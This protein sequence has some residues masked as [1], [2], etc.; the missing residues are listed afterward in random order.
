MC[1]N[2]EKRSSQPI[3]LALWKWYTF[4]GGPRIVSKPGHVD[5]DTKTFSCRS[6]KTDR[7]RK[8]PTVFDFFCVF[9][10]LIRYCKMAQT[11]NLYPAPQSHGACARCGSTVPSLGT[12]HEHGKDPGGTSS[13]T[14]CFWHST[15]TRKLL[16]VFVEAWVAAR[17]NHNTEALQRQAKEAK[18][19][20]EYH[21]G[22]LESLVISTRCC[23][24]E[25]YYYPMICRTH[26]EF[27]CSWDLKKKQRLKH[28]SMRIENKRPQGKSVCMIQISAHKFQNRCS[29]IFLRI[30][31]QFF[32][33]YIVLVCSYKLNLCVF[34]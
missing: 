18:D 2:S 32:Q 23:S 7:N 9:R 12:T 29:V 19:E 20:H 6:R 25:E 8:T 13:T 17:E 15:A 22:I 34:C 14:R 3:I 30:S 27:S 11:G 21:K 28:L 10:D 1:S 31:S 33:I 4:R 5:R 24:T 26:L 16:Q